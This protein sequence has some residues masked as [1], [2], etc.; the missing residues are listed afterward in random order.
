MVVAKVQANS[1]VVCEC[2]P[3]PHPPTC[4]HHDLAYTYH[5]QHGAN[6]DRRV[7]HSQEFI[8]I[9]YKILLAVVIL[10]LSGHPWAQLLS[11]ALLSGIVLVLTI[12]DRPYKGLD[13]DD[14]TMSDGD[15][16]MVLSQVLQ[17]F[18]YSMIA[19]CLMNSADR[20]A[21]GLKGLSDSVELVA[22]LAGLVI[23]VVQVSSMFIPA[24][25]P[26]AARSRDIRDD[27]NRPEPN[28]K[29]DKEI[30]QYAN[31]MQVDVDDEE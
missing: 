3:S 14:D 7:L 20:H 10:A 21:R 19:L 31:P 17:L 26:K 13:D 30:L 23:V 27:H 9:Y 16:Q 22:L 8:L 18:S 1:L 6:S 29:K 11:M 15:K 25:H 4:Q 2:P 12:L 5:V 24:T 28:S